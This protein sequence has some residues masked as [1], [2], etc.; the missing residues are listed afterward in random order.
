MIAMSALLK[1]S[2]DADEA[3]LDTSKRTILV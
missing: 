2:R 1:A 3:I